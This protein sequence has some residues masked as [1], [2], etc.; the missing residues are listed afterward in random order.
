MNKQTEALKIAIDK[1]E[2][3]VGDLQSAITSKKHAYEGFEHLHHEWDYLVD[4]RDETKN[5]IQACKEALEQPA[6]EP[7][8]VQYLY[9]TDPNNPE[10]IPLYTHP[11]S[12]CEPLTQ[13]KYLEL[14]N[15]AT[16][17]TSS[18]P[19]LMHLINKHFG[20]DDGLDWK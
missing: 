19:M 6:Q 7:V 3:H 12:S 15:N 5:I 2:N 10:L 17:W 14:K 11:A 20:I 9:K 4:E 18:L 16:Q 8:A 1:L 13:E